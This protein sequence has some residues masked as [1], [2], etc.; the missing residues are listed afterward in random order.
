MKI[1]KFSKSLL[2][3][4]LKSFKKHQIM[5]LKKRIIKNH[6]FISNLSILKMFSISYHYRFLLFHSIY[7]LIFIKFINYTL[8]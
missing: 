5:S 4:L 2:N 7:F 8:E 1:I 6:I 3:F